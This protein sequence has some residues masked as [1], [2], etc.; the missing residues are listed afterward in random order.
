MMRWLLL[1]AAMLASPA[2]AQTWQ[3]QSA[4]APQSIES[5]AT[6]LRMV[7]HMFAHGQ[8]RATRPYDN[9]A[10]ST[11]TWSWRGNWT[12]IEGQIAMIGAAKTTDDHPIVHGVSP[13]RTHEI[14]AFSTLVE[15]DMIVLNMHDG[16]TLSLVRC[17]QEA[18]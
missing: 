18:V 12:D 2:Y 11:T 15:E 8:F 4:L 5:G 9:N 6:S 14:R 13:S 17:F 3:C 16:R 10:A 1:S 7:L